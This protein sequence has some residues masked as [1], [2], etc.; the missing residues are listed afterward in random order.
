MSER[1]S[2]FNDVPQHEL[3]IPAPST[4]SREEAFQYHI[5]TRNFFA[6]LYERPLVGERLGQALISLL[7]RMDHYRPDQEQN[8]TEVLAYIDDQGYSDFRHCSD[9]ALAVLQFAEK[10]QLRALWTDAFV[11]CTGMNDD[12]D[13]SVEFEVG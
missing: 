4:L 13:A 7:E 6:W 5:T 12:L 11:H 2:Y 10:H 9:H 1:S 8:L 3:Y